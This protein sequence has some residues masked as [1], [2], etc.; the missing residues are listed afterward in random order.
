MFQRQEIV[1]FIIEYHRQHGIAPPHELWRTDK[2]PCSMNTINRNIGSYP[3]FLRSIGIQPNYKGGNSPAEKID[4]T[5]T[6]CGIHFLRKKSAVDRGVVADSFTQKNA[7]INTME[8]KENAWLGCAYIAPHNSSR[9]WKHSDA[10]PRNAMLNMPEN[11]FSCGGSL[12]WKTENVD[13][14]FQK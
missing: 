3:D 12:V 5:C 11:Y 13:K 6:G 8:K 1:D 14:A 4:L 7:P 2:T 10:V 9:F